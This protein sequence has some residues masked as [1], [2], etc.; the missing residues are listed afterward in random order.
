MSSAP[1][2]ISNGDSG[3]IEAIVLK[4]ARGLCVLVYGLYFRRGI[5]F[6]VIH[7]GWWR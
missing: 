6:L 4:S 1:G 5:A 3:C 7:R 2:V